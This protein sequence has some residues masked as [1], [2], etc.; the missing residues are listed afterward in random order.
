MRRGELRR[1]LIGA[2]TAHARAQRSATS[3]TSSS[4]CT[5]EMSA[6]APRPHR[7]TTSPNSETSAW[8]ACTSSKPATSPPAASSTH[9]DSPNAGSTGSPA[10]TSTRSKL[11]IS[12]RQ[13]PQRTRPGIRLRDAADEFSGVGMKA[14][15]RG[16][17]ITDRLS[18]QR[19]HTRRRRL[20][21][22]RTSSGRPRT[23]RAPTNHPSTTLYSQQESRSPTARYLSPHQSPRGTVIAPRP[24]QERMRS[25]TTGKAVAR[26]VVDTL[27]G[28]RT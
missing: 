25:A 28:A 2:A 11:S 14:F 1:C 3:P 8:A 6:I 13:S 5:N 7:S 9:P 20:L 17:D 15:D 27:H 23:G 18:P 12:P 16:A 10:H 4:N 19:V 26:S 21:R 22:P 24:A